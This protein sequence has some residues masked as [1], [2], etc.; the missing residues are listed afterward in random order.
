LRY[1]AGH[2]HI[3]PHR[4]ADPGPGFDWTVLRTAQSLA[5]LQFPHQADSG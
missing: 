3:A 2:E 4:K 1:V 5:D